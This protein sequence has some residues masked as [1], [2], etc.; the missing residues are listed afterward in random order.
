MG[1]FGGGRN[2]TIRTD[3]ISA[4]T[5]NTAEYG[6]AVMEVLGTTR[7]AGNVIYYDDFTAHEHR[8][9]Q[10]SGKGGKSKTTT[11]SYTYTVA[12]ILGLCEGPVKGVNRVWKGKD[13]YYYP[14]EKIGL[15]LFKGAANQQPWSYVTGKHPD[16]ALPYSGLAY[17]AGVID[18]GDNASMPSY[19]FE[20]M[21]QLLDT[22]DG[23]DVNPMDYILY[24]LEKSGQKNVTIQGADSFRSYCA[25]ADLLI[26]TPADA[27]GPQEAQKIVNEI[28]QLCGA[29]VFNSND[30]YK[31]VP[32]ADRPIGGWEPDNTI[33]YDLTTDDFLV[34]GSSCV[35]WSRKDSSEQ[36]NRFTVEYE[37]REN[38][39][40]KESVT[41]EDVADIA[42]RGVN[43][44][45]TIQA[46]YVYTKARAVKIAEEAARRNKVGKNQYTFK[47]DWPFCRL[48]PG[49]KVRI[50]D[51]NSGIINQVVLITA[52][53]EDE[54]GLPEFTAISWFDGNYGPAEYDV[55]EYDRPFVDFNRPPSATAV[56]AIF[57]PPADLT[58]EG[59]EVWIAAKGTGDNWGGC[60]VY[61]SDND[62]YYRTLGRISNN[63]R[64]GPLA[65][66]LSATATSLEVDINGTML[67]GSKQDAQRANTLLWISGECMSY[68]TATL[69]TNGHYRLDGLIRG[70]Y[71]TTPTTHGVGSVVVRCDETLLRAP[72]TKED[73]GK[74]LYFKF[75]SYNIFGSG[76][77]S[78]ADVPAY[79]YTLQPYYIPPVRQLTARNR[80]RQLKDGVTR[81]DIVAE[82]EPPDL[83]SFY[84]A[85]VW[86]KTNNVQAKYIQVRQG[87]P[88][89]ELGFAG[90][91]IYGG[92]GK[93]SAVI[94][95]AVVGDRYRI[96]V[97]TVDQ[98]GVETSPDA[99]PMVE[100]LVAL[101]TET[102]N[103]PDGFTINFTDQATAS[104]REVVNSDIAFYEVRKDD[105]PGIENANLLARVTGLKAALPL[106]ERTSTLYLYAYSAAGKYSAPAKLE[107][108]K[109]V[110][111]RPAA[112]HIV[113]KL[114]GFALTAA[115]VPAGCDGMNI[116]IDGAELVE[117]HTV[118]NVYT[119]ACDAGIYDVTV[120]YTDMFGEGPA[121]P[122]AR[123]TVKATVD[124]ALLEEQA[125]TKEKL[126]LAL[127]VNIDNAIRSVQDIAALN[128]TTQVIEQNIANARVA[129]QGIIEELNKSPEQNGY[130]SISELKN[131]ANSI[132]ST[133]AQNKTTQDGINQTLG[134]RIDQNASGI[135]AVV[136][137]LNKGPNGTGYNAITQLSISVN[138]LQS[139]V[140][141]VIDDMQQGMSGDI[142]VLSSQ[143]SQNASNIN[144]IVQ[145]LN[146]RADGT[147]YAA[148]TELKQQADGISST[149][150]QNKTAQDGTNDTIF[151][152]LTQT[153][154]GLSALIANL[155]S[156]SGAR[157]YTA[158][159]AMQDGIASKVTQD[160]V[161]SWFQ[162]DHTG[163]YIK[164]SL[165]NID[166][167]TK[168]GNNIITKNMIQTG[169]V[170]AD[171]LSVSSLSAISAVIGVLRTATSGA[172][173]EVR[174][175]QI[176]VYDDTR[177][178]V[179]MGVW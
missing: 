179:R 170:T 44:A 174:S 75:C 105:A 173:L 43:Q 10:R 99:S 171:K 107:Y 25:N 113:A 17:M 149:V 144:T 114:G 133:V 98:W 127:Q 112:P 116:Y 83:Q 73:I 145:N 142:S 30:T 122:D 5:V 36:Y 169:A 177:L 34:D 94:P 65:A 62:E 7:I 74:K 175:N 24:V 165:I 68:Q 120:A 117:A 41:Y 151:S 126:S 154:G 15:T 4:F 109:T 37:N 42:E 123:V 13:V 132:S 110:P 163:F 71:N 81:Y 96:A 160:D 85:R 55:H 90:E 158:I 118:N 77:Q 53:K 111:P 8:E 129:T 91:W 147:T 9:T 19:N 146:A 69:L 166:G 148:F 131:T 87:I 58:A 57:Q 56:P 82:W 60:T 22:G 35:I 80:Y 84:E 108:N 59:L 26:S 46:G 67:S 39:Y 100:I 51:E 159:Q 88:A 6:A 167:T 79:E 31:I 11:I 70:Q 45:P 32:L 28:A 97:T 93:T 140:T 104:W 161:S 47:L 76:E 29:Y 48:E 164:G 121:S 150:A 137:N 156:D 152:R 3:K 134:T 27:T 89:S 12:A 18:L 130:R 33:K 72:F 162:Q 14:D 115:P 52:V 138:G 168:I 16:K 92:S 66:V 172:R 124:A 38:G 125:V 61:V 135:T 176:L 153:A 178:R 155:N 106:T 86:Y 2:T 54:K 50:T 40:E 49:D 157:N 101:R 128:N 143:V 63:A 78:L 139:Q 119:H 141:Q 1:F 103:T 20:V 95:Q 102:P 136:A 21:G 23:T 64:L